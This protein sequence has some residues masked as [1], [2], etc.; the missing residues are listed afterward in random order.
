M[1]ADLVQ[2]WGD[3]GEFESSVHLIDDP[4]CADL[5][6]DEVFQQVRR[7]EDLSVV[8]LSDLKVVPYGAGA[9]AV[10]GES[11]ESL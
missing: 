4:A 3:D 6:P 10:S 8:F 7:D 9:L 1:A 11:H 5:R 2:P